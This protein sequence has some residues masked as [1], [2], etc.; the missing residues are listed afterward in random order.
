MEI[1]ENIDAYCRNHGISVKGFERLCGIYNCSVIRWRRGVQAPTIKTLKK[2]EA[3]TGI[4]LANWMQ[5]GGVE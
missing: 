3:A 4:P 2:I 1:V 5:K